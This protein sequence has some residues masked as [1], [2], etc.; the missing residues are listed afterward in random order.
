MN[1]FRQTCLGGCGTLVDTRISKHHGVC[2]KCRRRNKVELN[3]IRKKKGGDNL[4]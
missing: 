1:T 3:N 4:T 2:R